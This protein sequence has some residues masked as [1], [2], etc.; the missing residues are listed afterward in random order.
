MSGTVLDTVVS[1]RPH[2]AGTTGPVVH[3]W[4]VGQHQDRRR[5]AQPSANIR[6][7]FPGFGRSPNADTLTCTQ[8]VHE[9]IVPDGG[10]PSPGHYYHSTGGQTAATTVQAALNG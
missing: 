5:A 7:P 10:D 2:R 4:T 8:D 6:A 1:C 9:A 3:S